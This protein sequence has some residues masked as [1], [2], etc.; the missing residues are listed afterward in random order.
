M[1]EKWKGG[2]SNISL[3]GLFL[4]ILMD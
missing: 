3:T 4:I 2:K 1:Q